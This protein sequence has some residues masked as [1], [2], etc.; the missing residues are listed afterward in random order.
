MVGKRKA[1]VLPTPLSS[2]QSVTSQTSAAVKPKKKIFSSE[3]E[4]TRAVVFNVKNF[5]TSNSNYVKVQKVQASAKSKSLDVGRKSL[6]QQTP[7]NQVSFKK[8]V[9]KLKTKIF[10]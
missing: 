4:S 9:N 3:R 10:S 1:D 5:W 2:G 8:A 7:I 6:K